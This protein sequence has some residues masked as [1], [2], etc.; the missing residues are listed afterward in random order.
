MSEKTLILNDISRSYLQGKTTLEVLKNV[1]L[2]VAAGELIAIVGDSGSGKST[3]LQ[4]SG[5][6]DKPTSG[7]IKIC[8]VEMELNNSQANNNSR[9]NYIGFVYQYHHLLKDFT[10]KENAAMPKIIAGHNHLTAMR[11]AEELLIKLGLES[12]MN[13]LPGELSGGEQQRVAIARSLI[14][15]PPL[16]LADEPTG[17]LDPFTADEIFKLFVELAREH[18]TTIV[19]V[20]HNHILANKMHKVYELKYGSLQLKTK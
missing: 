9:L 10:A 5:L 20:T 14:N 11:D 15:K 19:M 2:E 18:N 1:N 17:N 13:N 12:R 7:Q 3:L 16:I 8:N 4:I 6:L